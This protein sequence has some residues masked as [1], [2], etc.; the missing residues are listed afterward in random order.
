VRDVQAVV[1]AEAEEEVVARDPGDGLGLEA[2]QLADA[3]VF[4][5]DVVAR[6]QVGE[7]L[8][9]AAGGRGAAR[10]ALP[11][12]LGVRKQREPQVAPDE[13]AA[14]GRDGEEELRVLGESLAGHQEAR[15]HP[16]EEVHRPQGLAPVRERDDDAVPRPH[17]RRE[18][19]LC[20]SEPACRDRRALAL[21]AVLLPTRQRLELPRA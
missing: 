17:K 5:D 19:G 16:A 13:P 4:M 6:A 18:L 9:R 2:E 7:G 8:E 10:S 20:L 12:D 14:R 11:E 21:E 3:V 15:I 1:A